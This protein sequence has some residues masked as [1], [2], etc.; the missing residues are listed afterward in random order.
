M[1]CE[2]TA[3]QAEVMLTSVYNKLYSTL[4][5][6][7]CCTIFNKLASAVSEV[8]VLPHAVAVHPCAA[9]IM[10]VGSASHH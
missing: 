1:Y 2:G 10:L 3:Y 6:T 4:S 8:G 7:L 5:C 9:G